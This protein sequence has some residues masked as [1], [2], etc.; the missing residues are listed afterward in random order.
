MARQRPTTRDALLLAVCDSPDDD[1]PRLVF[2][3]WLDENGHD[4]ERA[5]AEFIRLQCAAA[6]RKSSFRRTNAFARSIRTR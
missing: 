2:A 5:W 1:A 4:V 3:D 6:V